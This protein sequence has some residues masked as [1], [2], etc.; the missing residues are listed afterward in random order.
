ME[1]AT[2]EIS[3]MDGTMDLVRCS[4]LMEKDILESFV[5]ENEKV[6]EL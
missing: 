2:E 6:R 5:Q 3:R 1:G 4:G